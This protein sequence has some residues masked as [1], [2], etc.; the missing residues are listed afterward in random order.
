MRRDFSSGDVLWEYYTEGTSEDFVDN[1]PADYR[2][3]VEKYLRI[4]FEQLFRP[5]PLEEL[6]AKLIQLAL[7][8]DF[9]RDYENL[10]P[11]I[12]DQ[13]LKDNRTVPLSAREESSIQRE[14][15]EEVTPTDEG[16]LEQFLSNL[17][18]QL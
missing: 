17:V 8:L 4:S 12:A 9:A 1:V 3:K 5:D 11:A 10:T 14:L 16:D 6:R 7:L 18:D 13:L 15:E 2:E